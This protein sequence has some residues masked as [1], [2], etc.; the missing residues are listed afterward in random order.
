[1][2]LHSSPLRCCERGTKEAKGQKG[3]ESER[4]G[5]RE[6]ERYAMAHVCA[7]G[8]PRTLRDSIKEGKMK[9]RS[10]IDVRTGHNSRIMR[11]FIWTYVSQ[12]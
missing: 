12:L 9:K 3:R 8:C 7:K 6:G 10:I 4:E 2:H 5:G 1:M 11:R